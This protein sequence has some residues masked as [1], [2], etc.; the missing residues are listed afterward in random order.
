[1]LF[2][3][4]GIGGSWPFQFVRQAFEHRAGAVLEALEALHGLIAHQRTALA[5]DHRSRGTGHKKAPAA[6]G[7]VIEPSRTVEE[8]TIAQRPNREGMAQVEVA[9]AMPK[10]A[11]AM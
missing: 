6:T 10:I 9:R 7:A 5:V 11:K 8:I 2:D 1:M 4:K 3:I